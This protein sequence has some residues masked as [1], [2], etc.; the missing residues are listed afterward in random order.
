[1]LA[2]APSLETSGMC[3]SQHEREALCSHLKLLPTVVGCGTLR[4]LRLGRNLSSCRG[5]KDG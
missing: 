2:S 3:C 1:M 5:L 4:N